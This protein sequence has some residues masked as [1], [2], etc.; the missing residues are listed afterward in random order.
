MG[1]WAGHCHTKDGLNVPVGREGIAHLGFTIRG[2]QGLV[3]KSSKLRMESVMFT[4]Y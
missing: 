4:K 1:P 2:V 3:Q